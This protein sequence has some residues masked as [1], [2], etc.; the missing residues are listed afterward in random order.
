[1]QV[2]EISPAF[3]YNVT[4]KWVYNSKDD[5]KGEKRWITKKPEL[6]SRQAT[7]P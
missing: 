5:L 7:E 1:M 4:V 6:I 3:L 2:V